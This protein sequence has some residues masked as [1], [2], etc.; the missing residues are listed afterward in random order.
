MKF[1]KTLISKYFSHFTYFYRY[2]GY[3][4]FVALLL[5]LLVGVLDGFGLAMF[6]PLLQLVSGDSTADGESMGGLAFLV[7][8]FKSLGIPLELSSV[9]I[10][11]VVFFTLKGIGQFTRMY[12]NLI[13]R[14]FFVKTLRYRNVEYLSNYS[15][16]NFVNS[17]AGRIQNTMSGE[18]GKVSQGYVAYFNTI[19]AWVMVLVYIVLAF[20]T[21]P[22]FALLVAIGGV[23]SNLVYR[24]IYRKTKQ[25]SIN[26][27]KGGHIFQGLLLQMVGFFKYLKATG[28]MK[29]YGKRLR[30]AIDYIENANRKIGFYNALL[31]STREPLIIL[32]VV[33]VILIQ[34]KFL[35]ASLGGIILSLMFFYRSLTYVLTLQTNWNNFLNVSGSLKNMTEFMEELKEGKE[36]FGKEKFTEFNT[37]IKLKNVSMDY[38]LVRVIDHI[39]LQIPKNTTLALVGESGSGKTTVVNLLTGLIPPSDGDLYLDSKNY[40]NID[41]RSF[42]QKIGYITQDPVIFSDSVFNNVTRWAEKNP[43]NID[44]FWKALE[45]AAVADFVRQLPDQEESDLGNNGIQMSGGQKQRMSIARELYKDAEILVMDEATSALDSETERIIQEN[46]DSL[47]GELTIIIVA[48]RLS[49]IRN[50]DKIVLLN[51]GKMVATGTFEELI[52]KSPE[53]K[54]MTEL[55]EF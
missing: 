2:L 8:G 16:K 45:K 9:L 38:G 44:K 34:V 42:Q 33:I 5:S 55:Q 13:V 6:L 26:I 47:H 37:E 28:Y 25:V 51:Q 49:T 20:I 17:D 15:Y 50:V 29:P 36:K 35:A 12:Y 14:L 27:T 31:Y 32:V 21:N 40:Q 48:H 23:L 46:I 39:S 22:Q 10:I 18:V 54:R 24:V 53:F 43:Q 7:D 19:Q 41:I 1:I 30:S 52:K 4:I 3:R 11:I